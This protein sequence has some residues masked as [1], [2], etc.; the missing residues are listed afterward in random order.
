LLEEVVGVGGLYLVQKMMKM[1]ISSLLF[2]V[3]ETSSSKGH[4]LP[5]SKYYSVY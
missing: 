3:A 2:F 1:E 4:S 5:Y